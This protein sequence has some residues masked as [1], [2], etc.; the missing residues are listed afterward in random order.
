VQHTERKRFFKMAAEN[1]RDRFGRDALNVLAPIVVERLL[2]AEGASL[3]L[4]KVDTERY[5]L[6]QDMICAAIGSLAVKRAEGELDP[7]VVGR[8]F[9]LGM[10]AAR[11][12]APV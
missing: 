3:V 10:R 1:L 4:A 12:K 2:L 7:P 5:G 6:A 8:S 11:D 9:A